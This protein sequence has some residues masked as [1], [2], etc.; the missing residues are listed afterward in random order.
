MPNFA[1]RGISESLHQELRESADRNHRSL[2]GEILARLET[3][4]VGTTSDVD[5]I[6]ARARNRAKTLKIPSKVNDLINELKK[7]GRQ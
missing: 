4:I 7:S 6:L 5:V 2:N 3:S 1:L